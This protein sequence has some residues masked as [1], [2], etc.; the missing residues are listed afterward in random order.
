VLMSETSESP[1][2]ELYHPPRL[3]IIHLRDWPHWLG[4]AIIFVD[5]LVSLAWTVWST[6][7]T[8]M[9]N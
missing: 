7:V 8:R 6:L 1:F 5:V 4:V 3:G 9:L 2:D